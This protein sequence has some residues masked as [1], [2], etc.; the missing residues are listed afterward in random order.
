MQGL[1]L[2][3]DLLEM[4]DHYE[5]KLSVK[6]NRQRLPEERTQHLSNVASLGSA[7]ITSEVI[8]CTYRFGAVLYFRELR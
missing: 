6:S 1:R 7:T 5:V 4:R 3:F 8:A 2:T